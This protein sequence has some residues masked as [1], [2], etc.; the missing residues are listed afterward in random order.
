MKL[1]ADAN[2]LLAALIGGQAKRIL[3]HPAIE[4]VLTTEATLA[5]VRETPGGQ[6]MRAALAAT[7][8]DF[9][10]AP[11]LRRILTESSSLPVCAAS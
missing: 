5:E 4:E 11:S 9:R 2:V 3:Y 10:F 1:A 8:A 6:I 7:C